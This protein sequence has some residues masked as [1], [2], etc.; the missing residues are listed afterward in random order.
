MRPRHVLPLALL[1]GALLPS[2]ALAD[3]PAA[4]T[5]AATGIAQ[6]KA[7]L[8]ATVDPKGEAT[9]VRWDVGTTTSYGLQSAEVDA[10]SATGA[11]DVSVAIDGLTADTTYHVR[12]VATNASGTARGQDLTLRTAATPQR[13]GVSSLTAVSV[14]DTAATLRARVDPNGQATTYRFEYGLT[15]SFGQ[16]TEQLD[17]GA[18]TTGREV[19]SRVVG[20]QAGR[21][22]HFRVVATNATGTTNGA[23]RTFTT[24]L[25]PS[26]A[27]LSPARLVIPFGQ[28]AS[29]VGQLA[30]PRTTGVRVA[31]QIQPF[32]FS[33]P[34][35]SLS[36]VNSDRSGL[37]RFSLRALQQTTNVRVV[38]LGGATS[39]VHTLQSAVRLGLDRPLRA[40]RRIT[41]SGQ[42][43]PATP[44]ATASLQRQ[45]SPRRFVTV[46]RVQVGPDG[47]FSVTITG[48]SRRATYRVIANPRDGGAHV[49]ASSSWKHVAGTRGRR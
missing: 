32:P 4:T 31:L 48:R 1:A 7:V 2:V 22:Y 10:G 6:T 9:T 47:R 8:H 25:Y 24:P 37:Y 26:A 16:Q 21:Q 39:Q 23:R 34:F 27:S 5:E 11:K 38:A 35:A 43:V 45:T 49:S 15:A 30:G 36:S 3:A 42:V 40:G 19:R 17:A 20:L 28:D 18:A 44:Q 33:S 41:F 13:P 29:M 46:R 14:A 12:V